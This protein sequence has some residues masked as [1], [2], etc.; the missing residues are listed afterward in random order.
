MVDG[1]RGVLNALLSDV[2]VFTDAAGGAAGGA[3]PGYGAVLVAET[4]TGALISAEACATQV[5]FGLRA[6]CGGLGGALLLLESRREQSGALC[7]AGWKKKPC[8]TYCVNRQ[9]PTQTKHAQNTST[10]QNQGEPDSLRAD[11]DAPLII[12]EEV[13]TAA[14]RLLLDEVSR[15]GVVDGAHQGLL[16]VLAALG[17]EQISQVSVCVGGGES[18][19]WLVRWVTCVSAFQQHS[20]HRFSGAADPPPTKCETNQRALPPP[21]KN[22]SKQVR[23]GPLTPHAVRTLRHIREFLNVLFDM[24]TE[25]SSATIILTCIGCGMKNLSRKIT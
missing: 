6:L 14:A 17:P 13:G 7:F 23:L 25:P 10:D 2:Y 16:L 18:A 12:P 20:P 1:A 21:P 19:G 5:R 4:T 11:G 8:T 24:K 15:G 3:S 22:P 9:P